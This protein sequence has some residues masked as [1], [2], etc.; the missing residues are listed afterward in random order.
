MNV[1]V[2]SVE[3]S[4]C[5]PRAFAGDP[6]VSINFGRPVREAPVLHIFGYTVSRQSCCVHVHGV[7]PYFF[8]PQYDMAISPEQFGSQLEAVA[9][10]TFRLSH[11]MQLVHHVEIVRGI[12][13][14]GYTDTPRRFF[15]V[16]VYHPTNVP[17]LANL[18]GSTHFVGRRRWQPYEGHIPYHFQ[19]MI[20]FAVCGMSNIKLVHGSLRAESA[21]PSKGEK[22]DLELNIDGDGPTPKETCAEVEMDVPA[23]ALQAIHMSPGASLHHAR[24]NLELFLHS[25]NRNS[26][27]LADAI[28][29]REHRTGTVESALHEDGVY[30]VMEE[31]L[32][33]VAAERLKRKRSGSANA[34]STQLD[35]CVAPTPPSQAVQGI[36]DAPIKLHELK[37]T[38]TED[39]CKAVCP[40]ASGSDDS[41]SEHSLEVQPTFH[42]LDWMRSEKCAVRL[43]G[44]EDVHQSDTD[45]STTETADEKDVAEAVALMVHREWS[46]TQQ[47]RHTD[48]LAPAD[49][50]LRADVTIPQAVKDEKGQDVAD[51]S[52]VAN[53]GSRG[54]IHVGDDVVMANGG[55]KDTWVARVIEGDGVSGTLVVD[56]HRHLR[57][58][59]WGPSF[60]KLIRSQRWHEKELLLSSG[61]RDSNAVALVI[62]KASVVSLEEYERRFCEGSADD[63]LFFARF[64]YHAASRTFSPIGSNSLDPKDG[65][66]ST[67]PPTIFRAGQKEQADKADHR[68][69]KPTLAL[70]ASPC[71]NRTLLPPPCS[72]RDDAVPKLAFQ[73]TVPERSAQ[74][75]LQACDIVH[76]E[77]SAP[78]VP[79]SVTTKEE[80]HEAPQRASPSPERPYVE[81]LSSTSAAS[82][83]IAEAP[84]APHFLTIRD[85][86]RPLFDTGPEIASSQSSVNH[87]ATTLVCAEEHPYYL[88]HVGGKH[89]LHVGTVAPPLQVSEVD[90]N[91]PK[92]TLNTQINALLTS[93]T[94]P[95]QTAVTARHPLPHASAKCYR[96]E[97]KD[98]DSARKARIAM[99][100]VACVDI[101]AKS[102]GELVWNA[103]HDPILAA[104][105]GVG[106]TRSEKIIVV[107][108]CVSDRWPSHTLVPPL[109]ECRCYPSEA[110]V[111]QMVLQFLLQQDP[112][113]L[114]SWDS[115]RRGVGY[116]LERARIVLHEDLLVS[117]SRMPSTQR[118]RKRDTD[119][120]AHE[121]ESDNEDGG[122]DDPGNGGPKRKGNFAS[123]MGF[124]ACDTTPQRHAVIRICGR[125]VL[126]MWKIARSEL[127]QKSYTM[128]AVHAALFHSSLP[129]YADST[130]TQMYLNEGHDGGQT[131]TI[132]LAVLVDSVVVPLQ[133]ARHLDV[134]V[135]TSELA[136][137]YGI[138]FGEVLN[139]GSQ[140]RVESML[141]RFAKPLGYVMVSPSREQVM[142]QN[143]QEGI[144]LVMEPYS[145]YYKDPIVLLDFRSLYPSI[146]IAYNL[147]F[148]TCLGK[149]S[150]NRRIKIGALPGF[151][152]PDG[153]FRRPLE[154]ITIAPNSCMFIKASVRKGVLPR[155]L[156][157]VLNT[158]F[159]VQAT[160]KEAAALGDEEHRRVFDAQQLGLKLL[161]NVTYGYTA[162]TFTG[163]MPCS[164]IADSIVL[165]GRATLERAI[166]LIEGKR[167]WGAKVVYGDTDSLFVHLPGRSKESSFAIAAEM[168][169][170]IT[171][172]NPSPVA[173]KL[174]KVYCPS[175]MIVKKRYVGYSWEKVDQKEPKLDAKG[176]ETIRRDQCEA[177]S[178]IC[179]ELLHILFSGGTVEG[180]KN[181]FY[182]QVGKLQR[183][184][185]VPTEMIIRREVKL[186]TY[187]R[188]STLPPAARVALLEM[189][190]DPNAMPLFGERVPYIVVGSGNAPSSKLKDMVVHPSRLLRENSPLKINTAYYVEKHFVPSLNRM[191][192]LVGVDFGALFRNMPRS[193]R[194]AAMFDVGLVR[195]TGAGGAASSVSAHVTV[196]SYYQRSTCAVCSKNKAATDANSP[197]VCSDCLQSLPATITRIAFLR[198]RTERAQ[199]AMFEA[200]HHCSGDCGACTADWCR[201][202]CTSIDCPLSFGKVR[203]AELLSRYNVLYEFLCASRPAPNA[204]EW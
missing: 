138:L 91:G 177:T 144:P 200:C 75:H 44:D 46:E 197:P 76:A 169:R 80:E 29:S 124:R 10:S 90:I 34:S 52:V 50:L 55:A 27:V 103:A 43:Q 102:R 186:G 119:F 100:R 127:K 190:R 36:P 140:F 16:F 47:G 170:E 115:T 59:S 7:L 61:V 153:A 165:L 168:V 87:C 191:F 126:S 117:L 69:G 22:E 125:V 173:I 142:R 129:Q 116:L 187:A 79:S 122:A 23:D 68:P 123:T 104:C 149:I 179:T 155:M 98:D 21:V 162:A 58:T 182:E 194:R 148:S 176:I 38:T 63:Y 130:V 30:R 132:A 152:A 192:H 145:G 53:L 160:M 88:T 135:R 196:D 18:L 147:C 204:L 20:D 146:I 141:H 150:A 136:Q 202:R 1:S 6:V 3:Y 95:L 9:A 39:V 114:L 112:D 24:E 5:S 133:I 163:R 71:A 74:P 120:A 128:Q 56:W 41:S 106:E 26:Q 178:R 57:E 37:G 65:L 45:S 111:L 11:G 2:V 172:S 81:K 183:G 51:S 40:Q 157:E 67:L 64:Q 35:A 92:K 156:E 70:S 137:L 13:F 89:E 42:M 54:I 193:R 107:S 139:R 12:P 118:Q 171:A 66:P 62:A 78:A 185:L 188:E 60:N 159:M 32:Q 199:Q 175:L 151:K 15:K 31:R 161:A 174:E 158:R 28:S 97:Q 33:S 113:I 121:S 101:I 19:F 131:R 181:Y 154:E 8:V 134:F 105:V 198:H 201:T 48:T 184:D 189:D 17:K 195:G 83:A 167:E 82:T 25:Q 109:G 166:R 73:D 110:V 77:H 72:L 180:L 84:N 49:E 4:M 143:K 94:L 14:Y 108:F 96:G 203:C 99:L 86:D 164:D 93:H 85:S